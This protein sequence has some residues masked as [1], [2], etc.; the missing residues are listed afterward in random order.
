MQTNCNFSKMIIVLT[1]WLWPIVLELFKPLMKCLYSWSF[2]RCIAKIQESNGL[3]CWC[4]LSHTRHTVLYWY[5]IE[6]QYRV[7][8]NSWYVEPLPIL[9]MLTLCWCGNDLVLRWW[10]LNGTYL[11]IILAKDRIVSAVTMRTLIITKSSLPGCPNIS[12]L[13]LLQNRI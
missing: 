13:G 11:S 5:Q 6:I 4:T 10:S 3:P 8:T 12:R 9:S 7:C 1:T 2:E